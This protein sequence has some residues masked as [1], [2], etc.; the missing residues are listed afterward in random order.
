[1][2]L[3]GNTHQRG[4]MRPGCS[5]REEAFPEHIQPFVNPAIPLLSAAL[6]LTLRYDLH[7]GHCTL[8]VVTLIRSR[9]I[10]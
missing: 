9:G 8:L 7:A 3:N 6:A 2:M 1:M 4:L 10:T 5:G